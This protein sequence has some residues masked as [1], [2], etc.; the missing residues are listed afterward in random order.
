LAHANRIKI[1]DE[2]RRTAATEEREET[3]I[4]SGG[5]QVRPE[6]EATPE[7]TKNVKL[8]DWQ[9]SS[10]SSVSSTFS[11]NLVSK[12]RNDGV[13]CK[14]SNNYKTNEVLGAER[15]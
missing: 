11:S 8:P 10:F 2:P 3:R 5:N 4:K 6:G 7:L 13:C 1:S 12:H 9:A 14:I 15:A